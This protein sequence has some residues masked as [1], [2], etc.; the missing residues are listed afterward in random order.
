VRVRANGETPIDG[1]DLQPGGS[2]TFNAPPEPF[3]WVRANLYLQHGSSAV[4]PACG[5][6]F[7]TGQA[8]DACSEDLATAAMTSPIYVGPPVPPPKPPP[9]GKPPPEDPDPG[10]DPRPVPPDDQGGPKHPPT[11]PPQRGRGQRIRSLRVAWYHRTR[12]RKP[13]VLIH[14]SAVKGPIDLQ[15]RRAGNKHWRT[16]RRLNGKRGVIVHLRR[17][18]WTVR[19]RSHPAFG[20]PGPWKVKRVRISGLPPRD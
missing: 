7:P 17:A 1:Q 6:G 4:D 9:P 13:R 14:W 18:R 8:I 20:R 11:V 16:I 12:L 19:L 10:T 5:A 2:V 3:G 15:L